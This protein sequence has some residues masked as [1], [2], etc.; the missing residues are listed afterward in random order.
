MSDQ[1]VQQILPTGA[2]SADTIHS[3]LEFAVPYMAGTFQ[4]SFSDFQARLSDGALRGTAKV[5]SVQVKDPNLAAH[6]QSPE[7]FDAERFPLLSF[8]ALEAKVKES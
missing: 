5:A 8:E 3:T 4:S 6:L 7:F 2:W 1:A